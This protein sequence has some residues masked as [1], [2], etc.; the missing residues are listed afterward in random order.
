MNALIL[1]MTLA[2]SVPAPK[3]NPPPAPPMLMSIIDPDSG[4]AVLIRNDGKSLLCFNPMGMVLWEKHAP[5][6]NRFVGLLPPK[7]G[8]C[9][10]VQGMTEFWLEIV[11]G[12]LS[13]KG[14]RDPK[15]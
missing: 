10:V 4:I 11:R 1:T 2:I 6:H 7:G 14:K 13:L 3:V 8:K 15:R 12:D 9:I 5:D